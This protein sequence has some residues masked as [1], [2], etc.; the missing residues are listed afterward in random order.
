MVKHT[1][2]LSLS[3]LRYQSLFENAVE[4][5]FVSTP[6]GRYLAVN[7]AMARMHGYDSP[8][9]MVASVMDISRQMYADLQSWAAF[10]RQLKTKGVVEKFE[11]RNLRKDGSIIWTSANARIV[12]DTDGK[13]LY[14][15]GVVTDITERK[16]A[17]ET[18]KKSE[19]EFR[20]L[21]REFHALLDAIP[22][23]LTLQSPDLEVLWANQGA[24]AGLGKEVS[25][26]VGQRCYH[27]WHGRSE[28]CEI[29]PVQ[30]SF[31][32]GNIES[33]EVETPDGRFWDLRAVPIKDDDGQV[34]NVVEVGQNIT[35][36]RRAEEALQRQ[37]K[38]LTVLHAVAMACAQE[39]DIDKLIERVTDIVGETLYPDNC[40]VLL[41]ADSDDVLKPHPS[42]RGTTAEN[43][44][45]SVPL[46][47][48]I[49]GKVAASGKA[50]RIGDVRKEKV[51]LEVTPGVRSEL[52]VPIKVGERLIGVCNV[53]SKAADFFAE[54][55]EQ[56]LVT[57]A[58]Q[59]A[60]AFERLRLFEAARAAGEQ[61]E[62]LRQ[63]AQVVSSTLDINEVLKIILGQLKRVLTFDTASALLVGGTGKPDLI[64]GTG[65]ADEKLTSQAAGGLLEDS[66]I[67]G[68]MS[69]DL[70]PVI[71]PDVRDHP[72]WIWVP[73]AE[74]VRSFLAVPIITRQHM[75]GALMADSVQIDFFT[76]DDIRVAQ[77][78]A[79]HMA[80]AI[81]NARLFEAEQ[82]RRQEAETLREAAAAVAS[83][84][85]RDRAVDL[86]LEQLARVVPYD[87]ASV[88][89]LG[90]GHLE[91]VGGRGWPDPAAVIG[92]RFP[93]PGDNPNSIVIQERRPYI[94]GNAPE[95]HAPFRK[96]P[97]NHIRSW[98]GVPLIV[99]DRIIGML[100]VDSTQPNYFAEE[101]ARLVGAFA[102]QVAVAL[103]NA[104]L[105]TETL[106]R[107][108][109]TEAVSKI[110]TALR[111]ARN[112]DEMLPMMLDETLKLLQAD[113]GAVW[114]HDTATGM[115]NQVAARGWQG[116]L[117]HA[118]LRPG[119]GI[120]GHAF[121]A[122]EVHVTADYHTDPYLYSR[123]RGHVPAG[124]GG[125]CLP[126][127]TFDE[128]IGVF[129]VTVP[130]S[131]RLAQAEIDLL[132][133]I[134][135][136][137]GNAI[138][139]AALHSRTEQQVRRL[140]ALRDID[141]A[142]ASTFDLR[143]TLNV[144]V[145]QTALQLGADAADI[146]LFNPALQTL[147]YA[148]GR[149]FRTSGITKTR[150]RIGEGLAG[151]AVLQRTAIQVA[152][153][154]AD[155]DFTRRSLATDE[156]FVSYVSAPLMAK[157]QVKGVLEI[158]HR[159]SLKLDPDWLDFLQTLAG[160][161]AIAID[162]GQMFEGLQRSNQE[163]SLAYDTT[164]E[165]WSKA[166]ELRDKETEGHT[167][168]VSNLAL[169][170][171]HMLGMS[172]EDLVHLRRGVL[173]HDI[174]KMG[175]PDH[176][177]NKPGPLTEEEWETMRQHVQYAYDWL[178]PIAYLRPALEI[179]YY[180]HE[181][182]D[183][184]GYLHGLK[185]EEIPQAARIFA[186]V[187]VWDALLS[188]RPYRKAWPRPKV[189][190]YLREQSG[191]YFDA[192]VLEVFLGMIQ[193]EGG[194]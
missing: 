190:K 92:I 134:S 177:L 183:G 157:G 51:Y 44:S 13:V 191:K 69:Q 12:R 146:L 27:L 154:A 114:L 115:L 38:E 107:L 162:N 108:S 78:L 178:Y 188:D 75:S 1:P 109:E 71:I 90:E 168:H 88:Q 11:A 126:L 55:D 96:A 24:A 135:E 189:I 194:A 49:T 148:A 181:K 122:N 41:L 57:I 79:Q 143:V 100:A 137:A 68:Q 153:L 53:E 52:C 3:Q 20:K 93:V 130:S 87:S 169:Q 136:M 94:L 140:T 99:R 46:S 10:A 173:L 111:A 37:L 32:T 25:E 106:R 158:F 63:V 45:L 141:T 161:A 89:L 125:I 163:L 74:H 30:R 64:A 60:A 72:G 62:T 105:F 73:G 172:D 33:D 138:H 187:D 84:L 123:N 139:R 185:G 133:T 165:G 83:T 4:G 85:D 104:R 36:R 156:A 121:A 166:L 91:I 159:S 26:L 118:H 129:I 95:V 39:A 2:S 77:S 113:V 28:P 6:K 34:I 21:S 42:Y 144:L 117:P 175:I 54:A 184:T 147:S 155:A 171:A 35:A 101:S 5:I 186:V 16:Q 98:L 70:Q 145:D 142:I 97:H 22:D 110:S 14:Y 151:R 180:H 67:L 7:P 170:L 40:G 112:L 176:L 119:E 59:L 80:V 103:E 193:G 152:D 56:L 192:A 18:L 61:S 50:V 19:V 31:C 47:Q 132:T 167:R 23:N 43:I 116:Q 127:R 66:P 124:W 29:C 58:G 182:W 174:G 164:L 9:E 48:G 149:G 65:Y 81:E 120:I 76:N 128:T 160:Q 150:L 179:P 131:R 8:G 15:E 86:V 102:D 17:E 82:R